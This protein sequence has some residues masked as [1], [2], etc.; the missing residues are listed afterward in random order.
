MHI[1]PSEIDQVIRKLVRISNK[2]VV[3][4]DWYEEQI[5]K[6]FAAHNFIHQYEKIYKELPSVVQV[7]RIPIMKKKGVLLFKLDVKQSI[8]HALIVKR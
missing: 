4:V 7:Y 1:L 3:N 8:F 6:K 2:H 5:P